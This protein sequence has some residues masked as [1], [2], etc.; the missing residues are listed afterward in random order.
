MDRGFVEMSNEPG[1]WELNPEAC[2]RELGRMDNEAGY[3]KTI[4]GIHR[5]IWSLLNVDY[6]GYLP[7]EA[8]ERVNELLEKAFRYGKRMDYRLKQYHAFTGGKLPDGYTDLSYKPGDKR[9]EQLQGEVKF[10]E[11]RRPKGK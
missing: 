3:G 5:I 2:L 1:K 10:P 4:C 9:S 6:A 11:K 7:E 8:Q